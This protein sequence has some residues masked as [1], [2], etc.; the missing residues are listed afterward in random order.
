MPG[1]F[2]VP[3]AAFTAGTIS[4]ILVASPPK[5]S[6]SI[7]SIVYNTGSQVL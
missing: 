3:K 5:G 2:L 6:G 4:E 7:H 1:N